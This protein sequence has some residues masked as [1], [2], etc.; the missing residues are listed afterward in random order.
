ML[1]L[2][3]EDVAR[4]SPLSEIGLDSL[5][6][7]ELALGLEERFTL[8]APLS[9]TASSFTVNE[10]ARSCHR[11]GHGFAE[12]GRGHHPNDGRASSRREGGGRSR[13]SRRTGHGEKPDDEGYSAMSDRGQAF[14]SRCRVEDAG[15]V[16]TRWS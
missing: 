14:G 15:I 4:T 10:L 16:W 3:R 11:P 12:R 13:R 9:T 7:V 6:A 5:M 2:P 8:N 1:R